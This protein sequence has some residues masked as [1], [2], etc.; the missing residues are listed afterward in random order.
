MDVVALYPSVPQ[1]EAV[2]LANAKLVKEGFTA[3]QILDIREALLFITENNY[4]RFNGKI[5][6]QKQGV[7]MGFPLSAILA[8][9]LMRHVERRVFS[10]PLTIAYPLL[11]L[12]YVDD[13]IVAWQHMEEEFHILK[14]FLMEVYSTIKFTWE[15][16]KGGEIAFLDLKITKAQDEILF[17]VFHKFNSIPPLIPATAYQ[18]QHYVNAAIAPLI[19]RAFLLSSNQALVNIE[20]ETISAAVSAAGYAR[21]KY[22]YILGKVKRSLFPDT[23]LQASEKCMIIQPPLPFCGRITGRVCRIFRQHA[24]F[25]PVSPQPNL[26]RVLCNDRDPLSVLEWS[27]VYSIPLESTTSGAHTQYIGATS[28][29]LSCRIS[30]HKQSISTG[31]CDTELA[32]LVLQHQFSPRWDQVGILKQCDSRNILYIWEALFTSVLNPCNTPTLDVPSL[33]VNLYNRL[34]QRR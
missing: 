9:L 26:R 19:R 34:K 13:I 31:R 8:E 11:Y 6:L 25:L 24:L 15:K 3:Q 4:F 12:R 33:W 18:P 21:S 5:Y 10:F 29:M 27:G 7:P 32:R 1:F 22:R 23:T 30:E 2:M 28:R 14:N 16:E 20:L 17:S